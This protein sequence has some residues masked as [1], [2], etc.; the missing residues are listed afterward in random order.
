MKKSQIQTAPSYF[1]Q[2]IDLVEDKELMEVLDSGGIELFLDEIENLKN[3]GDKIY[4]EG[5]WTVN[6]IIMHL[7]DTERI[8]QNR[9]LRFARKDK[10]N[11]PGYEEN[12]YAAV[13]RSNDRNVE[14]L[15]E[16]YQ[17]TRL[18]TVSFFSNLNNEEL[19]R[20]GT[21]NGI[22]ISVLAIGFLLV[23]HPIH[24]FNVIRERYFKIG[25]GDVE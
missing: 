6:Q 13:A 24:H 15:L 18:S 2:Y 9:A 5:K 16:E 14:S 25:V 7:I 8:F 21:A 3:V 19:S 17:I 20:T 1:I 12:D 23:G 10:T 11:L 22:E 4:A